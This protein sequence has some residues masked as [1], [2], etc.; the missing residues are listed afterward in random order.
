MQRHV[1]WRDGDVVI[2]VP[3]KSGTTWTMNIVH[4]LRS[5]GDPEFEDI[6]V[7]VPW[8]EF[9]ERP[10]QPQDE[11]LTRWRE[12]PKTPRRA[13]K[14]HSAPPDLPYIEPGEG[15][16]DVK[17]I[18]VLRNPEEAM[19]SLK[20]F[21][22]K[23]SSAFFNMWE[24]PREALTRPDFASFFED[25]LM[26]EGFAEMI[27]GFTNGWWPLRQRPNVLFMHFSEMKRDHEGSLRKIAAF[28]GIDP[29]PDQWPTILECCSFPWMKAHQQKFELA[30]RSAVPVLDPGA[31]IRKGKLGA[32]KEDGW[33]DEYS[34]RLRAV[35]EKISIDPQALAWHYRGGPLPPA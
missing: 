22:E 12:L 25:I 33:T 7:E 35:G 26:G 30:S 32:A 31:M 15:R 2:S 5:G 4:Q 6:Y 27:L 9:V 14:T 8:L 21:L 34:A 10:G 18:V 29:R 24:V 3:A 28:L 19:V 23:H 16:P 20:P 1:D 17:Y 11:L 13:F